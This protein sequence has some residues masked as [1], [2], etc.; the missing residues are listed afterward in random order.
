MNQNPKDAAQEQPSVFMSQ[1]IEAY[2]MEF[3][4]SGGE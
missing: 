2:P 4:G 3:T 1:N